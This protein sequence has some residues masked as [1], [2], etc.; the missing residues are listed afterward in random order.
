MKDG[1]LAGFYE[2]GV[3]ESGGDEIGL[4]L[5]QLVG[6]DVVPSKGCRAAVG[7]SECDAGSDQSAYLS[8][9]SS[10]SVCAPSSTRN[11]QSLKCLWPAAYC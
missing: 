4:F 7:E 2:V 11:L 5:C 8:N 1:E 3:G 6:E 9:W 10:M